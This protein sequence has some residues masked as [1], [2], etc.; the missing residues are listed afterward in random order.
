MFVCM[1]SL[2]GLG[3]AFGQDPNIICPADISVSCNIDYTDTGVTGVATA[4][5]INGEVDV[6]FN[7]IITNLDINNEGFV[8]RRWNVVDRS[9]IF[10]DQTIRIECIDVQFE[11]KENVVA[12]LTSNSSGNSSVK[13]FAQSLVDGD[14]NNNDLQASKD[15][16]FYH[17]FITYEC[18]DIGTSTFYIKFKNVNEN[19]EIVEDI[20]TGLITIED[21]LP[22]VILSS[23]P[24]YL[25]LFGESN[26]EL[27]LDMLSNVVFDN[28]EVVSATFS[29]SQF[30]AIGSYNVEYTLS[31]V[32]GNTSQGNISVIVV[33]GN[34]IVCNNIINVS[35]LSLGDRHTE[36]HL[37]R[38]VASG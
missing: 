25:A 17:E 19:G 27:T 13:I 23:Q 12:S 38:G 34:T 18:C 10:C 32:S 28:C 37:V 24:V 3:Q 36:R 9:D 20:C 4:Y 30:N 11:C 1:F 35:F 2:L 31:D 26:V 6:E 8:R 16:L 33:S 5:D 22:P 7:D 29:Q 15:G 21:K 14:T